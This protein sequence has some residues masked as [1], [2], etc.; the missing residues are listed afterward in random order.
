MKLVLFCALHINFWSKF[1]FL[2]LWVNNIHNLLQFFLTCG[3]FWR[4]YWGVNVFVSSGSRLV[5]SGV[6]SYSEVV[7]SVAILRIKFK[8]QKVDVHTMLKI[9]LLTC[10]YVFKH[11]TSEQSFTIS[12]V[13]FFYSSIAVPPSLWIIFITYCNFFM[14]CCIFLRFYWGVN[15]S[16][17]LQETQAT[18][19]V[20]SEV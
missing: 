17:H 9:N 15:V 4:L 14:T 18:G 13:N 20:E 7:V 5:D 2:S 12:L 1:L 11:M 3:I 19:L 6:F 10:L 8:L 16:L